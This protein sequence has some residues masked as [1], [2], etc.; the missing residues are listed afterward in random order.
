MPNKGVQLP[1]FCWLIKNRLA[2]VACCLSRSAPCSMAFHTAIEARY[3][4]SQAPTCAAQFFQM[5]INSSC[6]PL[7]SYDHVLPRQQRRTDQHSSS[8]LPSDT[9]ER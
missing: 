1:Y 9:L 5:L 4:L 6:G 3:Y 8:R 2:F 7:G